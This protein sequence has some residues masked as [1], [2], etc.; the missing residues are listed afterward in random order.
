MSPL[1]C[2]ARVGHSQVI[3]R[4]VKAGANVDKQDSRGW[5]VSLLIKDTL[6]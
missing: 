4:L 6:T 1:M 3:E 2:A 5:T